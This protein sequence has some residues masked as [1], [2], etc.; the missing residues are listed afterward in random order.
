MLSLIDVAHCGVE[1]LA[2]EGHDRSRSK[3]VRHSNRFGCFGL[4]AALLARLVAC[5]AAL[6]RALNDSH[7]ASHAKTAMSEIFGEGSVSARRVANGAIRRQLPISLL[8]ETVPLKW[9]AGNPVKKPS[10]AEPG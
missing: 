9:V 5:K 3:D 4:F 1:L 10:V 6:G 8:E 7:G 2:P